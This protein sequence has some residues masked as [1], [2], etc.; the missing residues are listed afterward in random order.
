MQKLLVF[1]DIHFTPHGETIIGLDPEARFAE[2]LA[3]A[4][5]RHPDA[6][7]L[8]ITGDLAHSGAVGEY[9][10]L[11]NALKDC[12]IPVHL[13][14]GNHDDRQNFLHVF[15]DT[16]KTEAGFIQDVIDLGDHTRLI[17]LDTL[18]ENTPGRHNG[19]LCQNRLDW[20]T[21]ALSDANE[22]QVLL[23]MHHPPT[24]SG[25][26]GMDAIGLLDVEAFSEVLRNY[27]NVRQII[28]G[29]VHRTIHG[30][31]RCGILQQIPVTVFKSTCHQMPMNLIV[32]HSDLS[33]DEPGAYGILLV[34]KEEIVVHTE[35]FTL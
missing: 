27:S 21:T 15:P 4:V 8:L 6:A 26:P 12:P 28:A 20:L 33:V 25:F 13:M 30:A 9:E 18:N 19:R 31:F 34:E 32:E 7:H 1:T 24:R 3:H 14:L 23:F 17:L 16:P 10:R 2:G 11:Q 29:H 35:D 5:E 22:R